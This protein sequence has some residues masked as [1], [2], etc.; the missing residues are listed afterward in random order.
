MIHPLPLLLGLGSDMNLEEF[1]ITLAA[2]EPQ[3]KLSLALAGLW[4][5]E[6][7]EWNK[8][9]EAAKRDEGQTSHG[10]MPIC[11]ARRA[12]RQTHLTGTGVRENLVSGS[13]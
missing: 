13:F 12:T 8:A 4:W 11:I 5:D 6:K 2:A 3:K 7:G 9:H 10:C 1:R